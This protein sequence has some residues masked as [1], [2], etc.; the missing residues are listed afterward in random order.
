MTDRSSGRFGVPRI[1]AHIGVLL[2]AST[3]AYAVTLAA[4]TGLQASSE[5]QQ[6]AER[7]PAIAGVLDLGAKNEALGGTLAAAGQRYDELSR[8]YAAAGGQ[9]ADLGTALADLA[10]SVQSIDGVSRSLPATIPLP[11]VNRVVVG[12]APATSSTTGA[13][14]VP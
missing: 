11:K 4:V 9:L 13:S 14:G 10:A 6:I 7:A 5:A 3:A 8:S 2:G 12:A 1:P